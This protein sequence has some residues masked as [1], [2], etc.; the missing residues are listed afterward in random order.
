MK[1][2]HPT[3]GQ[4]EAVELLRSIPNDG[5][6]LVR[7]SDKESGTFSISFRF[8]WIKILFW[9]SQL[10]RQKLNRAEG[11]IKHCRIKQ[12]G[13]LFIIGSAQFESLVD[14]I[15][16]YEVNPLYGQVHLRIPVTDDI[17]TQ[18]EQGLPIGEPTCNS[19]PSAKEL[20]QDLYLVSDA[21]MGPMGVCI[22]QSFISTSFIEMTFKLICLV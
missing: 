15:N 10:K 16:Y 9:L 8:E 18:M 17:L 11:E 3:K 14:L 13:R 19:D 6:F 22:Q 12:E 5:A 2:Y 4:A 1:W 7:P 21:L 20:K